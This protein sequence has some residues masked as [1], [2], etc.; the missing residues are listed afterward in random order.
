MAGNSVSDIIW[1]LNPDRTVDI[2]QDGTVLETTTVADAPRRLNF[3][4]N[5]Q[6]MANRANWVP[7]KVIDWRPDGPP[8]Y[9]RTRRR[10]AA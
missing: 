9:K 5:E 2:V 4:R 3:Y 7:A 10:R 6:A 1:R 8:I